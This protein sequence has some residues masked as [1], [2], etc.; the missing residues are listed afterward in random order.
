MHGHRKIYIRVSYYYKKKKKTGAY[1]HLRMMWGNIA[2]S[3]L[4]PKYSPENGYRE[5]W[6]TW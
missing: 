6:V 2:K 1:Q 5:H 3:F 4:G